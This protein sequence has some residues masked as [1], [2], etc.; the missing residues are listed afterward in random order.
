MKMIVLGG[1]GSDAGYWTVENGRL[2][3]HGG[4]EI[5]QLADVSRSLAILGQAAKLKT[6]GLADSVSKELSASV[7]KALTAHLG[8]QLGDGAVVIVNAIGA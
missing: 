7:E 6:P 3:H 2:V 5:D 1:F 8:S 4:W